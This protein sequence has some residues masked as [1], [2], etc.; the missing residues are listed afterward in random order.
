MPKRLLCVAVVLAFV[1]AAS[2]AFAYNTVQLRYAGVQNNTNTN[3][4]AV[5]IGTVTTETGNYILDIQGWGSVSGY[6]VEPKY[7]SGNYLTY[8]LVPVPDMGTFSGAT[9]EF[10]QG[11]QAAAWVRSQN[12]TD[13]NAAAAQTAVWELTWDYAHGNSYNLTTGNFHYNSGLSTA[14]YAE[15][16][17]IYYAA[18]DAVDDGFTGAGYFVALNPTTENPALSWSG[19]Q[20][21][22][23]PTP[24]PGAMLLLGAGMLR[25]VSYGRRRKE[26][27]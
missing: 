13:G 24:L 27:A 7:S 19:N 14:Q 6:C 18:L 21:Y 11:Y 10:L 3:I 15:V 1:F 8:A 22:I 16:S 26:L 17:T 25:L 9:S 2:M 4:Y 5:G 12:Y 23:I 20:D